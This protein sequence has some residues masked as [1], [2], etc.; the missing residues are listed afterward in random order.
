M[1][2]TLAD[3]VAV[4]DLKAIGPDRFR[5]LSPRTDWQRVFG[6]LVVAQ[7]LVAAARTV[8]ARTPHALHG[9]F[10]RPGDPAVPIDFDVTRLREGR[11]FATR[12]CL[13][14]QHGMP[15]F[16]LLASFQLPEPGFDH[17]TAM[18]DVA[19]PEALPSEADLLDRFGAALPV[20]LR[21]YLGRE[22]PIEL[23]PVHLGRWT[24]LP[25]PRP[26]LPIQQVWMR[27]AGRLTD[28]PAQHRAVLAYMSDM[29][30][31]ETALLP[32]GRSLFE[33]GL[34]VASLDHALWFHR[35]ARADEWLLYAQDSPS[36]SG[37]RGLVRG[38]FYTPDGTLVASTAQEGLIRE[39]PQ[40]P[41]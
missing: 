17:Q 24:A 27:A 12:Q 15:I 37:A 41:A 19:P 5:G 26:T 4:L 38:A 8:E 2:F 9:V 33:P 40:R 36:A 11:S 14:R 29:T 34:Q 22:R 23:R 1:S 28:D 35:P 20:G 3:L 21:R 18:P 13:A 31:L 7:A 16:T 10:M 39:R 30:L 32:H 6:G 25:R